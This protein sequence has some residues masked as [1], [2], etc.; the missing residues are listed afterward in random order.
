[1]P[2]I[3]LPLSIFP[4]SV[5][6][7]VPPPLLVN[8]VNAMTYTNTRQR[9]TSNHTILIIPHIKDGPVRFCGDVGSASPAQIPH[10]INHRHPV[11]RDDCGIC[12]AHAL[13]G[14][15]RC[16]REPSAH[17]SRD[18][19]IPARDVTPLVVP[20]STARAGIAVSP[21]II[22]R[23]VDRGIRAALRSRSS[24]HTHCA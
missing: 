9:L 22:S 7:S 23:G 4:G 17:P 5:V 6:P 15:G 24:E 1:M 2:T 18:V 10:H 12:G 14:R 11:A 3:P 21:E 19:A 16:G 20:G 13:S 8:H